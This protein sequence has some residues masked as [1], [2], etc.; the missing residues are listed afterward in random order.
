[1]PIKMCNFCKATFSTMDIAWQHYTDVHVKK[2]Y[3]CS[4][5]PFEYS[6]LVSF[7]THWISE[8]KDVPNMKYFTR[9]IEEVSS[10][11]Y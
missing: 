3:V 9:N 1:M 4:I 7:N 11:S 6:D 5:C 10:K 8:H 2:Q